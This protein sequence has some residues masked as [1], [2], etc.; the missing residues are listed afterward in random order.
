[1]MAGVGFGIVELI[2]MMAFGGNGLPIGMP[3]LPEDARLYQVAPDQVI[4]YTT[5]MGMATPEEG[6]DNTTEAMLA[7]PE[8]RHLLKKIDSE[9]MAFINAQADD[10]RPD[11]A[12]ASKLIASMT[13]DLLLHHTAVY[14]TDFKIES[15]EV[16]G[17]LVSRVGAERAVEIVTQIKELL[18]AEFTD[19]ELEELQV[20]GQQVLQ[21]TSP[22]G[23]V[24]QFGS[25]DE[26]F[27]LSGGDEKVVEVAQALE[28]EIPSWLKELRQSIE[29]ERLATLSYGDLGGFVGKFREVFGREPAWDLVGQF[30]LDI[31][32]KFTSYSGLD[33]VGSTT[34]INLVLAGEPTGVWELLSGNGLS[35][36]SLAAISAETPAAF[37]L[38]LSPATLLEVYTKMMRN[39]DPF[40]ADMIES[41]IQSGSEA[42]GIDLKEEVLK[43]FGD[44]MTI[45]SSPRDGGLLL[46]WLVSLEVKRPMMLM[47]V[48]QQLLAMAQEMM[49]EE[50]AAKSLRSVE[51][52]GKTVRYMIMPRYTLPITPAW[53]LVGDELVVGLNPQSLKAHIRGRKDSGH[54]N[55]YEPL[56]RR[57]D[58]TSAGTPIAVSYVDHQKIIRIAYPWF[59]AM[60]Q[61]GITE[62]RHEMGV[63]FDIPDLPS[64]ASLTEDVRPGISIV[65]RTSDGYSFELYQTLPSGDLGATV[66]AGLATALPA[67][68]AARQAARR[69]QAAN[70]LR[71]ILLAM[72]NYHDTY[73]GFPPAYSVDKDG[74]PLLSWRVLILPFLEQ[75]PLYDQF[76]LD[77]PWDSEHNIKLMAK[78]PAIYRSPADEDGESTKTPYQGISDDGAILAPPG[79]DELEKAERRVGRGME[80]VL[81]GTSNTVL[82]LETNTENGVDWTSP[83]DFG[84]VE[85]GLKERLLGTWPSGFQVGMADG[86]VHFL[87]EAFGK[88]VLIQMF[89]M[90][91]GGP[92]EWY[93]E[94]IRGEDVPIEFEATAEAIEVR[95]APPLPP[96]ADVGG[97]K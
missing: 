38:S 64:V 22:T 56:A 45:Y 5:W 30:G 28:S 15:P 48:E 37:T 95:P 14:V 96:P 52:D 43:S 73:G 84:G 89:K 79:M 93:D 87:H 24:L 78:M 91:D 72:H 55:Q 41:S 67:V 47:Q 75:G 9:F 1:M 83:E 25:S 62:L 74:K 46:G 82:I 77:E 32:D 12:E 26:F 16:S 76:H 51:I 3:P 2:L 88:D 94:M 90:S 34:R 68:F 7:R 65:R 66:P 44:R 33:E 60:F 21:L 53:C 71:Q 29:I 23:Q 92:V 80:R 61:L 31:A 81:D 10:L 35:S 11:E 57:L 97:G 69:A 4:Y 18:K 63:D 50:E 39:M 8:I 86:S 49:G 42:F 40:T 19:G 85:M 6:S 59:Q 13:H 54:L 70:N 20:E 17:A 36:D 58:D 27:I